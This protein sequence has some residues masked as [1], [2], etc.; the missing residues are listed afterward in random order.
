METRSWA[1]ARTL[2]GLCLWTATAV[3]IGSFVG[4]GGTS[5][6]GTGNADGQTTASNAEVPG[7][8]PGQTATSPTDS[9]TTPGTSTGQQPSPGTTSSA[10]ETSSTSSSSSTTSSTPTV[11]PK[12]C[13]SGLIRCG[14]SC[15]NPQTDQDYCG[16]S[17]DCVGPN[18]GRACP[19]VELCTAGS[20]ACPSGWVRC[21]GACVNP[22]EDE[23][24]CGAKL[25]CTGGNAGV[26]CG[27]NSVCEAGACKS[28]CQ[29]GEVL[30]DGRC[31]NPKTD[32]NYCGAQNNCQG[33]DAGRTCAIGQVC[34]EGACKLQCKTGEV[35]CENRCVNPMVDNA[36]CGA[37]NDC[38]GANAG[39][40][41]DAPESCVDGTCGLY[42]NAWQTKCN[43]TCV[44]GQS[45]PSYCGAYG[46]CTGPKAGT[47]CANEEMCSQG[48][49]VEAG[50]DDQPVAVNLPK[51]DVVL[52]LDKSGSMSSETIQ[53]GGTPQTRWTVLYDVVDDLISNY[54][55]KVRF[56]L[57][58][59]PAR[60]A[61]A[62][63]CEVTTEVEVPI[64]N[65]SNGS[66]LSSMP[67]QSDTVLGETPTATGLSV[68]VEHAIDVAARSDNPTAI[69]LIADG[70]MTLESGGA[71]NSCPGQTETALMAAANL[72]RSR[73]IPVYS[74]GI[75]L[76]GSARQLL[77]NVA[78]G[79]ANYIQADN[80]AALAGAMDTILAKIPTCKVPLTPAPQFPDLLKVETTVGGV[81][82]DAP[83]QHAHADCAAATGAGVT[84]GFVYTNRS[85]PY[86]EIELCGQ[87]C[88]DYK[89]TGS[90]TVKPNCPPPP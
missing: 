84:R 51:S 53:V 35:L 44:N 16:A 70:G 23:A 56:G 15:I 29:A 18:S 63:S 12:A 79:A 47:Q 66:V 52:V 45:D 75:L 3:S 10:Q 14:L 83:W 69:M 82:S 54:N 22:Q 42:C 65:T 7:V 24:F 64:S 86:N 59:Y 68:A 37:S 49:C 67:G 57:K 58:L 4:C 32:F 30:C 78:G 85:G 13:D 55:S 25:D 34:S 27:E 72:A 81:K 36:F 71:G 17:G 21:K 26:T 31:I 43:G 11:D 90:V 73:D 6:T 77:E 87:T 80:K 76:S 89:S 38:A 20:C 46:D 8:V 2:R 19:G 74:V 62:N 1:C 88:L 40:R 48:R 9:T 5:G 33:S 41:C 28:G 61:T 50:C 39:A 60:N